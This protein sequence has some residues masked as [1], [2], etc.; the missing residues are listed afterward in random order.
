MGVFLTFLISQCH[1]IGMASFW[2]INSFLLNDNFE[3]S[4]NNYEMFDGM[5][6]EKHIVAQ[7]ATTIVNT[8]KFFTYIEFERVGVKQLVDPYADVR[9]NC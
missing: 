9:P 2:C 8:W 1:L 4:L 7:G 6:K 3:S 5:E